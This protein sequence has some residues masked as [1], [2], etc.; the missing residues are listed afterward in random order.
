MITK[1]TYYLHLQQASG[2]NTMSMDLVDFFKLEKH[3][4]NA[5]YEVLIGSD[6]YQ[7][8]MG[9]AV[10]YLIVLCLA[11]ILGC[12]GNILVI[13]AVLIDKVSVHN[14]QSI[15]CTDVLLLANHFANLP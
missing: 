3:E 15:G 12:V 11:T 5:T 9:I 6:Y 8:H 13:G 4:R 14:F 1:S 7:E 10:P 2:I